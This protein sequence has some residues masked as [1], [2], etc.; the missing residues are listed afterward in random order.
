LQI[1]DLVFIGFPVHSH[2]VPYRLENF[3]R[4]LPAGQ[5][6]AIFMTHGSIPGT[7]LSR[8]ALEEALILAGK[9]GYWA[10]LLLAARFPLKL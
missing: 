1:I 9:P 6:I 3:L 7:R 4:H 8:E 10:P 5:K 2:S